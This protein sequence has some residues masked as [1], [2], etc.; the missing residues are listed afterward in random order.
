MNVSV[1]HTEKLREEVDLQPVWLNLLNQNEVT[2]A[3][4][5]K[6]LEFILVETF[7]PEED[8]P[9]DV[10]REIEMT[11]GLLL[12]R[13]LDWSEDWEQ[14]G[15]SHV[16]CN[17]GKTSSG[18][19][20]L[21]GLNTT[22]E[23]NNFFLLFEHLG[24]LENEPI[25][26]SSINQNR[27]FASVSYDRFRRIQDQVEQKK[28]MH[29]RNEPLAIRPSV[30]TLSIHTESHLIGADHP[31][32][33]DPRQIERRVLWQ[34]LS[35]LFHA[36]HYFTSVFWK[37]RKSRKPSKKTRQVGLRLGLKYNFEK[38]LDYGKAEAR[39]KA[40]ARGKEFLPL[41]LDLEAIEALKEDGKSLNQTVHTEDRE[42]ML[43]VDPEVRARVISTILRSLSKSM[44]LCQLFYNRQ[45][46]RFTEIVETK[47][48]L[49]ESDMQDN[50]IERAVS[51]GDLF[52][53]RSET[54]EIWWTMPIKSITP[55]RPQ[56]LSPKELAKRM[57]EQKIVAVDALNLNVQNKHFQKL[58][59]HFQS[60][61]TLE[62]KESD[63]A[64]STQ[65]L[66]GI[67]AE[68]RPAALKL[69]NYS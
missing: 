62:L 19:N 23:N 31:F 3:D 55:L 56:M 69:K 42:F 17:F 14:G 43:Q 68:S 47:Y 46:Y 57:E 63:H 38:A 26:M 53:I 11:T 20:H 30:K 28:L 40:F 12:D 37:E 29:E 67:G 8:I 10:L 18:A 66:P 6:D 1:V 64:A 2:Q 58:V 52:E 27:I 44:D 45:W 5:I 7:I 35:T 51:F 16:F 39:R 9:N 59:R 60:P 54:P 34:S 41:Q 33:K 4:E 48:A 50:P 36:H 24:S 65:I 49:V 32:L 21:M 25:K 13:L 22:V 15:P 61:P